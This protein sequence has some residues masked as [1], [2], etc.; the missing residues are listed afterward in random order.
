M[1]R[2][3]KGIL[4]A[5]SKK[6]EN[7][8][9]TEYLEVCEYYRPL[10]KS[11]AAKFVRN[12]PSLIEMCY[13]KT[14]DRIKKH[15]IYSATKSNYKWPI[16]E[17]SVRVYTNQSAIEVY[18]K[19]KRRGFIDAKI[20]NL[21]HIN[22]K[23]SFDIDRHI[24]LKQIWKIAGPECERLFNYIFNDDIPYEKIGKIYGV[25]KATIC[26]RYKKCIKIAQEKLS[27]CPA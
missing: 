17:A 2:N 18:R 6:E 8:I 25:S 7:Q 14:C 12:D 21:D 15:Q 1:S 26:N 22:P 4:V 27:V 16:H 23:S 11:K 3:V 13:E 20:Y 10:I 5:Q 9:P 19:Y 24:Y